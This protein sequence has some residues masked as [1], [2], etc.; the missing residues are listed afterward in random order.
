MTHGNR[1]I[2]LGVMGWADML[3][4]L[5]IPY[6]SPEAVKLGKKVM[7]F[8]N[9]EGHLPPGS[10]AR[11]GSFPNFTGST[12]DTK[13]AEPH[14]QRHGHHHR[15]HRHHLHHRQRLIRR[16]AALCRLLPAHVMD[17]ER[18]GGGQSPFERMAKERGFYSAEL[19]K[20]IAEHG[21]VHGIWRRCP[22]MCRKFVT[23]HDISPEDHIQMQAAFQLHTDNAVSKTVN[24]PNTATIEDVENVYRWPTRPAARGHHLPRRFPGRAGALH[25]QE[26]R[27]AA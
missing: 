20:R 19:M 8:I 22:R 16:G 21:T 15:P 17:N 7:K 2:G 9:D 26:G 10:W 23:A 11:R 25:C 1:K 13:D 5:G 3:I 6:N 18:A 4:L 14:A 24:F 12:F 27:D